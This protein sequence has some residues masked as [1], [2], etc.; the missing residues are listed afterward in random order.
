VISQGACDHLLEL[1]AS[2]HI[3]LTVRD[4]TNVECM[5]EK[6]TAPVV[7]DSRRC[8][9]HGDVVL[10]LLAGFTPRQFTGGRFGF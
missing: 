2:L 9:F 7:D 5:E 4:R 10:L 8:K 6:P 3:G 1:V